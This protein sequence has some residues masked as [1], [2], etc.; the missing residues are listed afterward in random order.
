MRKLVV[1]TGLSGLA[2][3]LFLAPAPAI[4]AELAPPQGRVILTVT[5]KI[6][7]TNANGAAR[8]DRAMLR[9]VGWKSIET[10]TP[11]HEGKRRFS[12]VPLAALL[13]YVG[14]RGDTLRA[15]ALNDYTASLPAADASKFEVLLALTLDGKPMPVRNRGP[16]WIIYPSDRPTTKS[17]ARHKDK[18]VWQLK[19]LDVR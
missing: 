2:L 6:S 16:I 14:A 9:K 19:A 15:I 12:G 4:A 1:A 3:A 11:Y 13:S 7:V 17:T 10:F 18:M 8:F 5:G